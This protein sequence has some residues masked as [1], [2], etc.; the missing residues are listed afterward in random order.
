MSRVTIEADVAAELYDSDDG[1]R[2]SNGQWARLADQLIRTG[3]WRE[4]RWLVVSNG[5]GIFGIRYE[6]GLT[7]NQDNVWPWDDCDDGEELDLTP[8]VGVPV[9]STKYLTE[10]EYEA[11]LAKEARDG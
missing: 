10:K 1:E 2:S 5:G 11:H 3:R 8:L 6:N 9:T 4:S 7:E